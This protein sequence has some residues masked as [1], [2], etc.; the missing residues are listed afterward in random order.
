MIHY[1]GEHGSSLSDY[2]VLR[3]SDTL[4]TQIAAKEFK[5]PSGPDERLVAIAEPGSFG[6]ELLRTLAVRLRQV[7]KRHGIR[8]LLITSTVPGEGKTVIAANLAIT[9][10][11]HRSR[12]LLIDG[13]LRRATLSRWFDIADDSFET[14][15]REHGSRRLPMLRKA[16]GLPLWVVPAGNSVEMPGKILQ[17]AEFSEALSTVEPEFD[18]MVFD[19]TPMVPFGDATVLASLVDAVVLVTRKGITPKK[20]LTE[21]LKMLDPSKIVAT[22]LNC[23]TGTAHKYYLDYYAHRGILPPASVG[24]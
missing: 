11:R 19:S 8:K 9:L 16:E 24:S 21:M 17:S 20:E 13:D 14:N 5:I 7:K 1:E 18:W 12:V 15:W 10:S 23:G 3:L 4:E 2:D 6:A 22:V